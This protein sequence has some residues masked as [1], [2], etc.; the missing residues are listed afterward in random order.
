MPDRLRTIIVDDDPMTIR[1][2]EDYVGRTDFLEHLAS[3]RD[4]IEASNLLK[5]E[6]VDLVFLDVE[7]PGMTGLELIESL[8][9]P[10]HII[11]VS[12]KGDYA[13]SGF[14]H[15]VSDYLVKPVDYSRFLKAV[16]KLEEANQKDAPQAGHTDRLF[17]KADTQLVGI[18]VDEIEYIEALAD[19]VRIHTPDKRYTVYSSL[20][21]IERRLPSEKFMRT[22]RSYIVNLDKI[23]SIEGNSLSIAEK[24]LPVGVTY[25]KALISR[26]NLL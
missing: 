17:V 7:L 14:E 10:P 21:G 13:V 2:L 18:R 25:H 8:T 24:S 20:K 6:D 16:N 23:D 26:L 11:L 9:A 12:G 3:C 22:H 5:K 4:A 19:Y 1:I 15:D